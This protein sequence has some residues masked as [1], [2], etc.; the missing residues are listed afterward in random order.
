MAETIDSL[1]VS[2]GLDTDK[3]SFKKASDAIKGV[4]DGV[5]QLMATVGV[6]VGLDAW[7]RGVAR[8]TTE[9]TALSR[10]TKTSTRDVEAFRSAFRAQGG[11][12]SEANAALSKMADLQ[13]QMAAGNMTAAQFVPGLGAMRGKSSLETFEFLSERLPSMDEGMRIR[14]MAALGIA[15]GT[16]TEQMLMKGGGNFRQS[17]AESRQRVTGISPELAAETEKF[18]SEMSRLSDNFNELTKR[19]GEGLLPIANKFLET[20]NNFIEANPGLTDA[21]VTIGGILT[22]LTA[23]KGLKGLAGLLGGGAAAGGA[24]A[25]GKGLL[26][27]AGLY[28]L[29]ASM[30]YNPIESAMES[31]IGDTE[32]AKNAKNIGLWVASDWS[33]FFKKDEYEK[34]QRQ[35]DSSS[36]NSDAE[37]H[38]Q[39]AI[40]NRKNAPANLMPEFTKASQK[41][42]VPVDVLM[43]MAKQESSFNPNAVGEMTKWG[44]AK[45]IMQYL[46]RTAAS[47][48]INPL[49]P[50]QAIDAAAKQIRERLNKG[51]SIEEAIAHHHAGPN[52]ELWGPKTA[53]YVQKVT[54]HAAEFQGGDNTLP[55]DDTA[56]RV[57]AGAFNSSTQ[58]LPGSNYSPTTQSFTQTNNVT[59]NTGA[60]ADDNVR[61]FKQITKSAANSLT[62]NVF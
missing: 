60:N 11:D 43:G 24:A 52:R 30:L 51:E 34:Y 16:T 62:S 36:G 15:P 61:A 58:A 1:L 28:G 20:V 22:A 4:K 41:Y 23:L 42:G 46:P 31:K 3:E 39:S 53:D 18:N 13:R 48:G 29:A 49:D 45:G 7:T 12:V 2:L 5:V 27:K 14:A 37:Q 50:A 10:A 55:V 25:P 40:S 57:A 6:G 19:M 38:V 59:I 17:M 56:A 44:Q 21:L 8:Y 54:G 33:V 9:I 35:L 47:M 32:F 26:G